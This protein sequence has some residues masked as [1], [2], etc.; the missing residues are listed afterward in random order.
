MIWVKWLAYLLH[1][2]LYCSGN[3]QYI[4]CMSLQRSKRE[5]KNPLWSFLPTYSQLIVYLKISAFRMSTI[6]FGQKLYCLY[7]VLKLRA[8]PYY[9]NGCNVYRNNFLHKTSNTI[10]ESTNAWNSGV[11]V[12][13]FFAVARSLHKIKQR[14]R[15]QHLIRLYFLVLY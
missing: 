11:Y 1:G 3:M 14:H 13:V 10:R 12:F 2:L 6:S 15:Y 7:V 4:F 9:W 5:F 8:E